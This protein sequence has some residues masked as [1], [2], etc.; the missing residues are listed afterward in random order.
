MISNVKIHVYVNI[1]I[2]TLFI[3]HHN[4]S[5]HSHP[6][7]LPPHSLPLSNKLTNMYI[8][9]DDYNI[10]AYLKM[11]LSCHITLDKVLILYSNHYLIYKNVSKC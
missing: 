3:K 6:H 1:A 11:F 8:Y 7:S 5:V 10:T 4:L 2:N 9:K